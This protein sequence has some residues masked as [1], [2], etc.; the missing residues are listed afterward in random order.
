M[1]PIRSLIPII[2]IATVAAAQ[3]ANAESRIV[4]YAD[5][6]LT[7]PE[8]QATLDRRIA[9]AVARVCGNDWPIALRFSRQVQRC[10]VETLADVQAQRNHALA[11]ARTSNMQFSAR[12]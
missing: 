11:Q 8:G 5:L 7:S 1:K 12:R 10:R 9:T 4:S 2:L 3:P 6:D